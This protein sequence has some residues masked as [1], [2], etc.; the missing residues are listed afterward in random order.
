MSQKKIYAR[1]V[2]PFKGAPDGEPGGVRRFEENE[3]VE[4]DLARVAIKQ[5]WAKGGKK[6]L[7]DAELEKLR[8]RKGEERGPKGAPQNKAL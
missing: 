7:T 5:G 8:A 1:V 2:T 3:L 4:G 6:E